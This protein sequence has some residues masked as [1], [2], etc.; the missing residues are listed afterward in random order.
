[1][2]NYLDLTP[3]LTGY[4]LRHTREPDVARRLRE[5]TQ[6]HPRAGMITTAD[7]A[8][9]LAL[10]VQLMQAK[11]VIE[12]GTFTGYAT[13]AMAGALPEGGRL[14]A[15]DVSHAYTDIGRRYWKEA[16]VD[17]RIDLRIAPAKETLATLEAGAFDLMFIDADKGGYDAY[18]EAGLT[19]L[20]QGG[21]MV[22][23][24]MLWKGAVA[25]PHD[26]ERDTVALRAL[27]DK[28]YRDERV[29]ASL[30]TVADGMLLARKR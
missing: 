15:C 22:F 28:I 2:S 21:L 25:D 16:G 12:V 10:L 11:R 19:L 18:Y 20:R 17:S 24:N 4:V 13:L 29:D 27:N 26:Q 6:L 1:M 9:F 7:E 8:H 3:A 23:D 30:L 5:E 14:V